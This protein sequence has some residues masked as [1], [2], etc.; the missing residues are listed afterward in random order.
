MYYEKCFQELNHEEME[1]LDGGIPVVLAFMVVYP[2][3]PVVMAG[4][5][6]FGIGAGYNYAK[7]H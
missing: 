1:N 6:L 3:I 5:A 2:V 4:A 7:S